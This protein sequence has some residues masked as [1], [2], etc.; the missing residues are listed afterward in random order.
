MGAK[1][2]LS[3]VAP[4]LPQCYLSGMKLTVKEFERIIAGPP[5]EVRDDACP[6][7][8]LRRRAAS[9][10]WEIRWS[11]GRSFAH[12]RIDLGSDADLEEA[13]ALGDK[14]RAIARNNK[15]YPP[16]DTLNEFERHLKSWRARHAGLMPTIRAHEPRPAPPSISYR[17]AVEDYGAELRRTRRERTADGYI[18]TLR[19][20]DFARLMDRPVRDIKRTEIA[21]IIAKIHRAHERQAEIAA[22]AM[23]GLW[24]FLGRDDM[25]LRTGV[26]REE[27]RLLTPPE[28]SLVE[29][30]VGP[31][32]D[33][34]EHVPPRDEIGR[35][36]RWLRQPVAPLPQT[37][38]RRELS[39]HSV[40]E[41]DR[42]AALL[43]CYTVQRVRAVSHAVRSDFED[44][45]DGTGI[46]RIRPASRK[47]ASHAARRGHDVGVH[48]IPLPPSAWRIV[49]RAAVLAGDSPYLF[50]AARARRQGMPVTTMHEAG[51]THLFAEIPG[52]VA[53]PHD[54]RRAFGTTWRMTTEY[55][56]ADV[57]LILDHGAREDAGEDAEDVTANHY[58]FTPL[59]R[60]AWKMMR[61]WCDF[62]DAAAAHDAEKNSASAA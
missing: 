4:P 18:C 48:I 2:G 38:N 29:H 16:E 12:R 26:D 17:A 31:A 14:F 6:G 30:A 61:E 20:P 37:A 51:I 1:R 46:W 56:V 59:R 8:I 13:R 35:I 21:G 11:P 60:K 45:G 55:T 32:D 22:V 58:A 28:R 36:M 50:P 25:R 7:L 5:R 47:G 54:M 15:D 42:L 62:V 9:W 19:R 39:S 27:M 23:R 53:S 44:L 49:E 24:R 57:G 52:C 34:G 40:S 10:R 43:T 33:A 3:N 41:R